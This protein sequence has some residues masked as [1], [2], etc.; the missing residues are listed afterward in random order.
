MRRHL[1]VRL[2]NRLIPSRHRLMDVNKKVKDINNREIMR[3]NVSKNKKT[4]EQEGVSTKGKNNEGDAIVVWC[5][6]HCHLKT[7]GVV[8]L[9]KTM[10][11][12][13][14]MWWLK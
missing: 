2:R 10:T 6:C 5:H 3:T 4:N 8:G 12:T 1:C 9:T 14:M 11:M 13:T 7:H